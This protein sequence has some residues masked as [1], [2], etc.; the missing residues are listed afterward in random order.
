MTK[1][2]VLNRELRSISYRFDESLIHPEKA[3]LKP[4]FRR[5][6]V[7]RMEGKVNKTIDVDL[8]NND[9][10]YNYADREAPQE[11]V[12]GVENG[13]SVT[14]SAVSRMKPILRSWKGKTSNVR[15]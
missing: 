14:S 3:K 13:E 9:K 8:R 6:A 7:T 4:D 12:Y 2:N 15:Y 5:R 10:N 11:V 1:N